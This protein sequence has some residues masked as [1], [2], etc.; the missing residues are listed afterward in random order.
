LLLEIM[1]LVL[2]YLLMY[3]LLKVEMIGYL[4]NRISRKAEK[5]KE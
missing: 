3:R 5:E 1:L 2:S 4:L